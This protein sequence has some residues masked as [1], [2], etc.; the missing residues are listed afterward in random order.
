MAHQK[1]ERERGQVIMEFKPKTEQEIAESQL[2]PIGEYDFEVLDASH[3][4]SKK[5]NAM[6]KLNIGLYSGDAIRWRIF[7]YLLPQLEAK[8]RHFCDSTGLLNKYEAGTLTADDCKGRAGRVDIGHKIDKTGT[9]P[10]SAAVRD[11]FCRAA[12]PLPEAQPKA[13]A[14]PPE[15]DDV[16]F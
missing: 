9:Y 7:D 6:I 4:T 8:L 2:P 1:G 16:P 5:G 15:L 13:Q 10:P 11:Y 12:K 14:A 3:E